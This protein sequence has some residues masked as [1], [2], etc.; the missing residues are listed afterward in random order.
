MRSATGIVDPRRLLG[1]LAVALAVGGTASALASASSGPPSGGGGLAPTGSAPSK[2]PPPPGKHA[3]GAWLRSVT[4]TEYWPAPESWFVGRLVS[5]PGLTGKHRIDWLYSAEGVS[6]QG[7]GIGLDG[8]TYHIDALGSGGWITAAGKPTNPSKGWAGGPPFW[9]A[10]GYWRTRAGAV[11]FPLQA[12]GWFAG[13]GRR[14]VPL[15]GVSFAPG[16]S[17]PLRPLQ[18]IAVDPSV[19]PLGSRVYIPAYRHDGHG[20]WFTAQDT[21]GA[22]VGHRVDVY[23]SPPASAGDPGQYLTG[24]RVF[25]IKPGSH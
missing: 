16:P 10:G 19:I 24:Q 17:L 3:R 22:I 4:I 20:G 18:S 2:T 1:V 25:V 9:R 11:T 13:V 6:M 23:R 12:G 7:E 8:R 15:Q 14:Y 5:A 21:G